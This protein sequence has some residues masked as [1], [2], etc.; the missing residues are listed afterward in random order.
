KRDL[1]N[2]T[3]RSSVLYRCPDLHHSFPEKSH[4]VDAPKGETS[5]RAFPLTRDVP[6][7]WVDHLPLKGIL[8]GMWK[9][10]SSD[11]VRVNT[12]P[13]IRT[14][15]CEQVM[16]A[17]VQVGTI[18]IE[19]RPLMA[20]ALGI[21]SE[22]YVGNWSVVGSLNSFAL[23]RKIH[24]AGWSFFFMAGEVK[25]KSFGAVGAK[26]IRKALKRILARVS[27]CNFNCLEV[28][29]ITAKHF[30]GVPYTTVSANWRHIQQ[31]CLL[32]DA[33]HRRADQKSAEWARA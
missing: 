12:K 21:E 9:A 31:S 2:G 20:Q 32:D 28:T 16:T 8:P 18:L 10:A 14:F 26:N 6:V 3:H 13:G 29:G 11:A 7:L 30:V 25:A 27:D 4:C 5:K 15:D 17:Q 33:Q 1:S 19:D 24:A 22:P 23:D